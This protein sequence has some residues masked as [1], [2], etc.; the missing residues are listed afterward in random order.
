MRFAIEYRLGLSL[1]L[2]TITGMIGRHTWPF[3]AQN[4]F[5]ALI[6]AR[7]PTIDARFSYTYRFVASLA[8]G[9][10][11]SVVGLHVWHFP[12]TKCYAN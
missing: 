11:M 8:L 2:S 10:L 1:A 9:L 3:P 7:Q 12:E 4:V 6:Q 5:L